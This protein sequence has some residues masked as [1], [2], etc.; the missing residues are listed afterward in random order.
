MSAWG[1]WLRLAFAL[2]LWL[3]AAA[4]ASNA[5]Q[6]GEETA[7]L[8][9]Q[10]DAAGQP[11]GQDPAKGSG[12]QGSAGGSGGAPG[13]PVGR[14]GG[15]EA[16]GAPI[17]IPVI[18]I[19]EGRPID[20]VRAEI[21]QDIRKQ[22]GGELCVT[23]RVEPRDPNHTT[24]EFSTTDP[25]PGRPA[26]RRSTVVIVSGTQPCTTET[27]GG[28]QTSGEGGTTTDSTQQPTD[29]G[30]TTGSTQQQPTDTS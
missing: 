20:E 19:A 17:N 1:R 28:D 11:G 2:L 14:G 21:E 23:L 4:C 22:C 12:G 29:Q 18:T 3:P 15:G 5:G 30:G 7:A 24:C 8:R 10:Q 25:A 26:P 27:S 16:L 13:S 9:S 6:P